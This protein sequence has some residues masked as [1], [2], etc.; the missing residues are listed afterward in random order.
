MINYIINSKT[1]AIIGIDSKKC[2]IIEKNEEFLVNSYAKKIIEDSCLY[3]GSS[4]RGKVDHSTF[5]LNNS[6]KCPIMIENCNNSIFF[7]TI[8]ADSN[9][10]IWISIF[11]IEKYYLID[12][13]IVILFKNG[14]KISTNM[15]KYSIEN[16][17]LKSYNL[18][19]LMKDKKYV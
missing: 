19:N 18:F 15:S 2:K 17:M 13:L 6:Y 10:C 7:P 3:Y 11:E 4:Y 1:L 16:Q 12:D 14:K 8:S 5:L 9:E